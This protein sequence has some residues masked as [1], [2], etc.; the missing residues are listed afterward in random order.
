MVGVIGLAAAKMSPEGNVHMIDKDF[1]AVEYS[2]KNA[3][4]NR[5]KNVQV[6]LSNAFDQV[7]DIEFDNVISNIPAKVNK[8][9]F[10][11]MINDAKKH[12]KPGGKIYI[13]T[14]SGLKDFIKR[15]L[16]DF[17]GNYKK[18]AQGKTY[19]AYQAVKS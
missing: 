17:F 15:N 3:E 7:P 11:I 5:I 1:V 6:Y 16:N 2:K 12:L 13:V 4:L 19:A 18:L 10:W 8:E 14:L 9:F